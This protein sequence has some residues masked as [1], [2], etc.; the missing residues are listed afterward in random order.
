MPGRAIRNEFLDRVEKG[1]T[2]PIACLYHCLTRCVP[3][4][5]PYCIARA[6][7]EAKDGRFTYGYAFC[8]SNAWRNKE[9]GKISVHELFQ[10]LDAEYTSGK[11]SF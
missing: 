11:T 6:L 8:G 7:A 10:K 2:V 5:S 1:E 9:D 4:K 3:E